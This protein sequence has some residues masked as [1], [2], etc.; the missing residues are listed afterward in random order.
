MNDDYKFEKSLIESA[1]ELNQIDELN[2]HR[3]LG[4]LME[5]DGECLDRLEIINKELA[6][7]LADNA[8]QKIN[9]RLI[10]GSAKIEIEPDLE[11]KRQYM[12]VYDQ[13]YNKMMK[14]IESKGA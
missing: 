10:I 11:K 9:D 6:N 5:S 14:I 2:Y 13:L 12:A 7:A 8:I 4:M 3:V 1:F